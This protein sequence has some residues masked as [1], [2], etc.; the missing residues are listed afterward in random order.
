MAMNADW[1]RRAG[2]YRLAQKISEYWHMQGYHHIK[3]DVVPYEPEKGHDHDGAYFSIT[4]NMV[5]GFPPLPKG[6]TA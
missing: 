3:V 2:A 4:S 6:E 1:T 5:N